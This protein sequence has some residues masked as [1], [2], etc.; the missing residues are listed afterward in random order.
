MEV[1][2]CIHLF[3][4]N[5]FLAFQMLFVYLYNYVFQ[6]LTKMIIFKHILASNVD[7]HPCIIIALDTLWLSSLIFA[8][9]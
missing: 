2:N 3:T 5:K 6:F 8:R 1:H 4:K 9:N 7:C